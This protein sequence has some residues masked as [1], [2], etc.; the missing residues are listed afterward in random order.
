MDASMAMSM[1]VECLTL[2]EEHKEVLTKALF[3]FQ[4]ECYNKLGSLPPEQRE[5]ID[6]IATAL[7]L[8]HE[9]N[10]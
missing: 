6:E 1:E 8:K 3:Y 4:K 10:G 9:D 5:L 7:Q 2:R